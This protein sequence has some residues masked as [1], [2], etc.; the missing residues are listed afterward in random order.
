MKQEL[1]CTRKYTESS[2]AYMS[3]TDLNIVKAMY[4]DSVVQDL[5]LEVPIVYR[6]L[7]I[8][9]MAE[10]Y[11]GVGPSSWS[12]RKRQALTK[13]F[14]DYEPCV[15]V[16]DIAQKYRS[17]D[18]VADAALWANLK[19]VWADKFGMFRWFRRAAWVELRVILPELYRQLT[20]NRE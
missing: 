20:E 8:E 18:R 14:L 1:K 5:R 16:H 11:N 6:R 3:A 13:A 9:Q 19:K 12:D 17:G 2:R 15:F 10:A 7:S 4:L